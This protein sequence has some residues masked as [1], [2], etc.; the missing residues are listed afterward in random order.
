M[1]RIIP[2]EISSWKAVAKGQ[3]QGGKEGNGKE[4]EWRRRCQGG[5]PKSE[6][7][8]AILSQETCA[9]QSPE[10]C[11]HPSEEQGSLGSGMLK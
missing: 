8:E 2:K 5:E 9:A 3:L 4:K 7:R 1:V 6:Y 11:N 10:L